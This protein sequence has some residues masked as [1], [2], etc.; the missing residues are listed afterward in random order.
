MLAHFAVGNADGGLGELLLKER[1]CFVHGIDPV[2]Q[3]I[4]LPAPGQLLA[5]GIADHPLV[6]FQHIGL[7]RLP[8]VGGLLQH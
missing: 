4:H 2:V 8:V 5:D 3:V 1:D 7:H 6:V